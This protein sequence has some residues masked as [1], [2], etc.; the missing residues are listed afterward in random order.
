MDAP[1]L[2]L[3]IG[4]TAC[5]KSAVALE[6]ARRRGGEILS[7]D[8][9]KLYRRLEIGVAKPS[10][11]E[12]AAVRHHLIDWKDP[13]ESCSVA[14]WLAE[15]E[16]IAAEARARGAWLLAEGG[17]ALY[18]KALR[19]GLFE[20]PGR[21]PG[22][23]ARLDEEADARGAGALHARLK[24]LDPR[25]AAKILPG[26]RRRIVRALEVQ[27]LT[28]RP[29]S[30]R[31]AQWG[32]LRR[33]LVTRVVVL[34]MERKE[35]YRRI[36]ARVARMLD[37]GWLEE[38]RR[39]RELPKPLSREARQAL[40]YRTLFA[41][42][43]GALGLD[44][45]RQRICYDTHHF[46]RRQLMWFRKFPEVSWIEARPDEDPSRVADRAAEAFAALRAR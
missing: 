35:L 16:R 33:D 20:G 29:I 42:L 31:Q 6:L 7:V 46:A 38:C 43:D 44:E 32:A 28:G 1:E 37:A 34:T 24:A 14:E 27:M 11:A 30:E 4:P 39:L 12:R 25:A 22:L 5:G 9:M 19:E 26:D 18:V 40:G 17:T 10:E 13:W 36:D 41:H 21:D 15:A 23:R 45:A 8:S 3:L 2:D